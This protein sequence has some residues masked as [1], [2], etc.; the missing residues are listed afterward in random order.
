MPKLLHMNMTHLYTIR[1]TQFWR[2]YASKMFQ[3]VHVTMT[4]VEWKWSS[5]DGTGL[6]I[7][8]RCLSATKTFL[9]QCES[10]KTW[11]FLTHMY[12][13][14]N[15]PTKVL[16]MI[17]NWAKKRFANDAAYFFSYPAFPQKLTESRVT[18]WFREKNRPK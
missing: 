9:E 18:G 8:M 16:H 10:N 11:H 2:H 15:L 7:L 13:L 6:Q 1:V 14:L 12:I 17:A 3:F 5:R 4:Y